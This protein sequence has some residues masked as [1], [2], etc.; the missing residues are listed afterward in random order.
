ML[1]PST[2]SY[3]GDSRFRLV[4]PFKEWFKLDMTPE[5]IMHIRPQPLHDRVC[6]QAELCCSGAQA[7]A[8][9][10][11]VEPYPPTLL[12]RTGLCAILTAGNTAPHINHLN[13]ECSVLACCAWAS[14]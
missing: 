3:L 6:A 5:L 8:R 13:S 9:T 10:Y 7:A 14:V 12:A 1:D 4:F 11:P 2:V